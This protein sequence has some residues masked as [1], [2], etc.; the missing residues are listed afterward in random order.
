MLRTHHNRS[1][2]HASPLDLP[3]FYWLVLIGVSLCCLL[4]VSGAAV[5]RPVGPLPGLV[6]TKT[7][8][9]AANLEHR[10]YVQTVECFMYPGSG[11]VVVTG[12]AV[13]VKP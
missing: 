4:C 3:L 10:C 6:V 7:L 2:R 1:E 8:I 9:N 12:A 13:S 5:P 11:Q